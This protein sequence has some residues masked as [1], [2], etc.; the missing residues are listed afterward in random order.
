MECLVGLLIIFVGLPIVGVILGKIIAI[1]LTVVGA[2]L[3]CLF[4]LFAISFAIAIVAY[5]LGIPV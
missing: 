2:V 1:G 5:L 4:A 3:G